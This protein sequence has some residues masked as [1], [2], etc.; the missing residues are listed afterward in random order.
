MS[1]F[2]IAFGTALRC[3]I[4]IALLLLV[5]RYVDWQQLIE[6][7]SRARPWD[8]LGA[9]LAYSSI[10]VLEALRLKLVVAPTR[11]SIAHGFRIQVIA[12]A[13]A[14]VT[15]GLIGG[16]AY[17]LARLGSE[18]HAVMP[19]S[20]RL[21]WLRISGLVVVLVGA[22]VA[23]LVSPDLANI[24]TG[25]AAA[26]LTPGRLFALAAIVSVGTAIVV[27]AAAPRLRRVLRIHPPA[28]D[29]FSV[30]GVVFTSVCVLMLRVVVLVLLCRSVVFEV[31]LAGALLIATCST[32]AS[33]L[34]ISIAGAG[35]REG[36][37][38]LLLTALAATYEQSVAVALL[39]R[40]LMICQGLVGVA[41]WFLQRKLDYSSPIRFT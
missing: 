4:A 7:L 39:G 16:D 14:N 18:G 40:L 20:L 17:K 22:G 2:R 15:P 19:L 35:V 33:V 6:T 37:I 31:D 34:P 24:F 36:V 12:S 28:M 25:W 41:W 38:V 30:S 32:L 11:I 3:I 26:A 10:S 8:V 1:T 27:F 23:F 13:F 5:L 29:A 21:I 9:A